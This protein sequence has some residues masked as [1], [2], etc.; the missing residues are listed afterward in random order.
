LLAETME[1][2]SHCLCALKQITVSLRA[3]ATYHANEGVPVK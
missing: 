1:Q 3:A 2:L